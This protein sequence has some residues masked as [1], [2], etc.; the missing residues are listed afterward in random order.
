MEDR[1]YG[2]GKW[3]GGKKEIGGR[4]KRKVGWRRIFNKK[5]DSVGSLDLDRMVY[6]RKGYDNDSVDNGKCR[7]SM[8]QI[9]L[10]S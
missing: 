6:F 3:V 2:D 5:Y 8:K 10:Y 4:E 9:H 1:G 7:N